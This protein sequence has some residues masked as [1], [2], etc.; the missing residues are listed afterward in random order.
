[1]LWICT[2]EDKYWRSPSFPIKEIVDH[3]TII[4]LV[5][6]LVLYILATG[7]RVHIYL[8]KKK[9]AKEIMLTCFYVAQYLVIYLRYIFQVFI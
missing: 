9:I 3:I 6:M 8:K 1:M 5:E 2:V 4:K 7:G